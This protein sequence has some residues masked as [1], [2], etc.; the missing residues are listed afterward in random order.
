MENKSLTQYIS[1]YREIVLKLKGIDAFQTLRG[2]KRGLKDDYLEYV[3]P[4]QP[5]DLAEAIQYAQIFD[6]IK[7]RSARGGSSRAESSEKRRSCLKRKGFRSEKQG[8]KTDQEGH[9]G[10]WSKKP[11]PSRKKKRHRNPKERAVY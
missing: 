11:R 9:G 4:L 7:R 8:D 3:E 10:H 6:D 2:F 1:N 5:K